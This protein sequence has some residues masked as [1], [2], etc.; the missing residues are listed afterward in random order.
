MIVGLVLMAVCNAAA[1]GGA[2]ALLEKLRSGRPGIDT[3]LFLVIHLVLLS[4]GVLIAGVLG[5]LRPIPLGIAGL[6]GLA[7][8]RWK[9]SGLSRPR[10]AWADLDKGL[11][12]AGAAITLKL[13]VQVWMLAPNIPDAISYHLPKVAEWTR[14][15]RITGETGLDPRTP[16]PA[17]FELIELWWVVFLH[18]DVVIELAGLEFLLLAAAATY[19]L[20]RH[21]GLTSRP[22]GWAAVLYVLT[23]GVSLQAVSCLNDL[24]VAALLLAAFALAAARVPL[25]LLL[26]LAGLGCGV[27]P[28]FGFALPGVALLWFLRR[29]ETPAACAA[30]RLAWGVAA[31]AILIGGVWYG[32]NTVMYG[33]PIHP[34]G[35]RGYVSKRGQIG[36]QAGPRISSLTGNL[37]SLVGERIHDRAAPYTSVM[38]YI[39]AWGGVAF[40]CGGIALL[41]KLREPGPFRPLGLAFA[42]SMVF[43]FLLVLPDEWAMRFVLFFPA[44]LAIAVAA[45]AVEARGA[46]WVAG[47]A[48]LVQFACT[49]V[50]GD[51][52]PGQLKDLSRQDWRNRANALMPWIEAPGGVV[53]VFANGEGMEYLL[54]RPDYSRR[55]VRLREQTVEEVAETLYREDVR[56]VWCFPDTALLRDCLRRGLLRPLNDAFYLRR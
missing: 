17:G 46:A 13:V 2:W 47:A 48:A 12:L 15:G 39:A 19:A 16:F 44:L 51:F 9:G 8:L 43:V 11:L 52:Y 30:P 54:Y 20:A 26:A 32:R 7:L 27:K 40:A 53:G 1:L 35:S 28:T 24:P 36:Q 49:V 41:L 42:A 14:A 29:K 10:I 18:H 34:V 33:N 4:A 5:Q 56:L 6:L 38:K 21:A 37:S 22:A 50:P 25:P 45:V 31:A 23:P 3:V 55:V